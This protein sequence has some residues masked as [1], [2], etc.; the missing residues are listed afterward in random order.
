V[1]QIPGL[2]DSPAQSSSTSDTWHLIVAIKKSE[3]LGSSGANLST[4][5]PVQNNI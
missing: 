3:P 4:Y 5:T 2:R 1:W